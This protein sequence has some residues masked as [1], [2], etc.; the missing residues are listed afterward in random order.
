MAKIQYENKVSLIE[1]ADIPDINKVKANDMNEI[2]QVVNENDD[3]FLTNGLNVSNEVDVDYKVNFIKGKNKVQLDNIYMQYGINDVNGTLASNQPTRVCIFQVKVKP[4]T[5]YTIS[6]AN[7][8]LIGNVFQYNESR[9]YTT[10]VE[11][12]YA[13]SKQYTS[14][15]TT[16]Y[17]SFVLRNTD[18]TT[19][20]T[21]EISN[22]KVQV[23][24]GT[25]T[26]Y[27][28]YVVPSIYVDG[29]MLVSKNVY[30]TSEVVIGEWLG[31][32]L[33]R[34]VIEFGALP[35]NTYKV[36]NSNI[37]NVD[38]IINTN[39]I[40]IRSDKTTLPI[41]Y[42]NNIELYITSSQQVSITT[43]SDRS[44]FNAYITIEY[45]KTTDV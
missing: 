40:A 13:R 22:I 8:Y 35:N 14:N 2:K 20:P 41:P 33:Y 45:T 27:E 9:T 43:T 37:S 1:N 44:A 29:E 11:S 15:S 26:S 4:N 16:H 28:P 42:T 17:I 38:K 32:P 23:E 34:K 10:K 3:K 21:S 36:V 30:S 24:E 19:I 12:E 7:G 25:E 6:C 39:G 31:K 5:Q 18:N